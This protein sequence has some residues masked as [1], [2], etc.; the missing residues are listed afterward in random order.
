MKKKITGFLPGL[1]RLIVVLTAVLTITL[2]FIRCASPDEKVG[3]KLLGFSFNYEKNEVAITVITKGCT[4]KSDFS[5]TVQG[6][7]VTVLRIKKDECKAMP[8]A[9]VLT[10]SLKEAGLDANKEYSVGNLFIANPNLA[11]VR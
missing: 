8:E 3:E 7:M 1:F 11:D 5:F 4:G 6:K 10:Y 9:V 2:V